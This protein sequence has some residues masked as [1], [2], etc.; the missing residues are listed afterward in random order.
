MVGQHIIYFK[1]VSIHCVTPDAQVTFEFELHTTE[2][3]LYG[4]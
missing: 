2:E 3:K 4:C 1:V